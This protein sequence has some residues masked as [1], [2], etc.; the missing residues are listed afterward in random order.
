MIGEGGGCVSAL[1][2]VPSSSF[3]ITSTLILTAT[4]Q[5]INAGGSRAGLHDAG[6]H[7]IKDSGLEIALH[8]VEF[9]V[10]DVKRGSRG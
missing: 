8:F 6:V 1:C 9:H 10:L 2:K 3:I 4:Q 5:T 7:R